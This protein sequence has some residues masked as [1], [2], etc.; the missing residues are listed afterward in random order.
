M[1][2]RTAEGRHQGRRHAHAET[3]TPTF[4]DPKP[5]EGKGPS[6]GGGAD[7]HSTHSAVAGTSRDGKHENR[8]GMR[9]AA[10]CWNL[11]PIVERVFATCA[12]AHAL[13]MRAPACP[14]HS[15]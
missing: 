13:K 15:A 6:Q 12:F 4:P 2:K 5:G 8:G 9:S 1:Q 3:E 7:R 11:P 14:R 10:A